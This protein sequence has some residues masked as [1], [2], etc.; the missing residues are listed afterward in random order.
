MSDYE[1]F[2]Q[3]YGGSVNDPEFIDEWLE[4]QEKE[5]KLT[6]EKRANKYGISVD[7]LDQVDRY[8]QIFRNCSFN[9]H[10][11][12]NNYI[13]NNNLWDQFQNI[14]SFNVHGESTHIRGISPMFYKLVCKILKINSGNGERLTRTQRY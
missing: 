10:W 7:E 3:M 14:R 2:C 13:S 11:E 9:E 6:D 12:V 8:V 5:E 1:D 4:E